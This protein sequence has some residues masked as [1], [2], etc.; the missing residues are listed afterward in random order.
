MSLSETPVDSL[1]LA[2]A[3]SGFWER[4]AYF[5]PLIR[6]LAGGAPVSREQL[7]AGLGRPSEEVTEALRQFEDIIY[8]EQGRV[9]SAGLS[10]LPTSH[11]FEV[12]GHV[13][14]TWC[15]LDTLIF[16]VWTQH[17]AQISSPCP[18]TGQ[19]IHLTVTPERL[20]PLD[21]PSGVLSLLIQDGLATCCNIREAFC[22]FS[23][24]F[25]KRQ[26]ASNWL[27]EY[28]D[29]H[30]LSIEEAFILGQ[31]LARL[32]MQRFRGGKVSV[33]TRQC[34]HDREAPPG[35]WRDATLG[36]KQEERL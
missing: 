25:A 9:V 31:K 4:M 33:C 35:T 24:F 28:L 32:T 19:L 7:A 8:D 2:I 14:F 12:N 5:L 13:L 11:R 20:E 36:N 21:P 23:H 10:L 27:S 34:S 30:L 26:A 18:V 3:N 6:L 16:P 17:S 1:A 15:A 29:A 22:S